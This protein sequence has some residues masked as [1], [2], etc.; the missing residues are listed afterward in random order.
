MNNEIDELRGMLSAVY[1]ALLAALVTDGGEKQ[2]WI[3]QALWES[4]G[5]DDNAVRSLYRALG[6]RRG[7]DPQAGTKFASHDPL[8]EG[9][10]A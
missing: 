2:Y 1:E 4:C 5:R 9:E 3:E 10:V 8:A 7:C 6:W